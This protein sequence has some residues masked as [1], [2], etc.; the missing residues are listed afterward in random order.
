MTILKE[1]HWL[2]PPTQA[3]HYNNYLHEYFTTGGLSK[4]CGTIKP[5]PNGRAQERPKGDTTCPTTSQDPSRWHPILPEQW[6]CH[7]E[8]LFFE[9]DWPETNLIN[10]K[11]DSK[12][13][14]RDVLLGSLTLLFSAQV[15]IPNKISCFVSICTSLDN[16]FPSVRQEPTLRLWK[17]SP[18]LQQHDDT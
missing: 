15:P 5:P 7:Q 1:T 10:T 11:S 18:F 16:P 12:P 14:S 6:V 3:R 17:G 2:K 9:N 8:G 4:E 13:H